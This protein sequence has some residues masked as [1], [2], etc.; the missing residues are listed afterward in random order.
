MTFFNV[1]AWLLK[2]I[3][4]DK[5]QLVAENIALR[6]QIAVLKRRTKRPKLLKSDR[7]FW[8]WLSTVWREWR[9]VLTIVKP[10]TVI[11]WHR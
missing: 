1:F 8:A 4:T 3:L 11:K 5:A 9:F 2:A 7:L 6:Q 10:E